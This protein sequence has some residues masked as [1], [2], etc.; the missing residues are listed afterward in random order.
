VSLIFRIA[1]STGG[2]P[3]FYNRGKWLA[4]SELGQSFTVKGLDRKMRH[5]LVKGVAALGFGR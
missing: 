1:D 3:H 4:E 2:N 5:F